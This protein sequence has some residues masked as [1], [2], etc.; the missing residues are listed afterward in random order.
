MFAAFGFLPQFSQTPSAGGYGSGASI[1]ESGLIQTPSAGGYGFGASSGSPPGAG[2]SC[3]EVVQGVSAEP[4]CDRVEF[5]LERLA[6]LPIPGVNRQ[7]R[8]GRVR[9]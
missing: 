6:E 1:T 4:S 9:M 5:S 8:Q 2:L 7:G 3:S